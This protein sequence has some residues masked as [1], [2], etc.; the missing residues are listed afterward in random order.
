MMGFKFKYVK[1]TF[2]QRLLAL[3]GVALIS[4]LLLGGITYNLITNI[5]S[6]H[7]VELQAKTLE[8]L[9]LKM[10]KNEKDFMTLELTN[11]AFFETGESELLDS[12]KANVDSARIIVELLNRNPYTTSAHVTD[13]LESL[14]VYYTNYLADFTALVTTFRNKGFK[15]YGIIGK[16]RE[17]IHE[18]EKYIIDNRLN[19]SIRV[20]MLTLRRHEKD[21]LLR[22]DLKYK[23]K[24]SQEV[25]RMKSGIRSSGLDLKSKK[26][27]LKLTQNYKDRFFDV[28][29]KDTIIGLDD[30]TGI[31]KKISRE[32][33]K[34][35]PNV[36]QITA[37]IANLAD[38]KIRRSMTWLAITLVLGTALI[39]A[40]SYYIIRRIQL[41]LGGEP[42]E[43][44]EIADN[45]S[46]GN[47][48]FNIKKKKA[49][50]GVMKSMRRML[51]QLQTFAK[52]ITAVTE[53][54]SSVSERMIQKAE[55]LSRTSTE[56]AAAA[57]QVLASMEQMAANIERNTQNAKKTEKVSLIAAE[58]IQRLGKAAGESTGAVEE[59]SKKI[60]VIDD[61]VFQTRLLSLNASII[62][63]KS[64]SEGKGF[65]A[66]AA[67]VE[68]L[69]QKSKAEADQIEKLS[70]ATVEKT[71]EAGQMVEKIIKDITKTSEFVQQITYAGDEQH[72]GAEQIKS[73]IE[74]LN[75]AAQ[76]N[77]A[78]SLD[79]SEQASE[80][81]KQA[82]EL[83]LIAGFFSHKPN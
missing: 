2:Q 9:T 72:I 61:I 67:E 81:D 80:L 71:N 43:V 47:L 74:K 50:T 39:V 27:M 64:G 73:F 30:E 37:G 83:Q 28:I 54:I 70:K 3:A 59:I 6:I 31:R 29:A 66:I 51:R 8:E 15:D 79:L 49:Q 44:A 35:E 41:L 1:L 36:R 82:E 21:Y 19:P 10:R 25:V 23:N 46:K 69:A 24:F 65:N 16:M 42:V 53:M 11:P 60:T 7:Q 52:S 77:A 56:Q 13:S 22:K 62:A 57:E 75:S 14:S 18:V 40:L 48:F 12:F 45:I 20:H 4:F 26:R 32:V 34:I 33:Q 5:Q 17:A 55:D 76:R 63:A 38:I 58:G 68:N 78:A